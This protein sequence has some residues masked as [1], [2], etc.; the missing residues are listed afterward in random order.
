MIRREGGVIQRYIVMKQQWYKRKVRHKRKEKNRNREQSRKR[1]ESQESVEK[2]RPANAR[3]GISGTEVETTD[4]GIGEEPRREP[5]PTA[6][7]SAKGPY[8]FSHLL[9]EGIGGRRILE[10]MGFLITPYPELAARQASWNLLEE[11]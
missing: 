6:E 8:R 7:K 1:I 4:N 9:G 10:Y 2:K 11:R 3:E 5:N